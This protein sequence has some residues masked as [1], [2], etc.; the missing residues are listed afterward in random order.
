[1]T[2]D[3]RR[4]DHDWARLS[5]RGLLAGGAAMGLGLA[6][7]GAGWSTFATAATTSTTTPQPSLLGGIIAFVDSIKHLVPGATVA[8]VDLLAGESGTYA[9][10][11]A[12]L[13]AKPFA[14]DTIVSIDS[15]TKMFTTIMLAQAV[16]GKLGRDK[17]LTLDATI[18]PYLQPYMEQQGLTLAPIVAGI[19]LEQLSNY[20]SGFYEHPWNELDPPNYTIPELVTWLSEVQAVGEDKAG[21][22]LK[23]SP[24]TTYFYSDVALGLLGFILA[25]QLMLA[26]S[27]GNPVYADLVHQHLVGP[28]VLNLTDTSMMPSGA[29]LPRVATGYQYVTPPPNPTFQTATTVTDPPPFLGGGGGLRTTAEDMVTFLEALLAPPALAHL[30]TAVPLT[31]KVSFDGPTTTVGTIK[32]GL[33]WDPIFDHNGVTIHFKNGGG[34]DGFYTLLG[35]APATKRALFFNTNVAALDVDLGVGQAFTD[36]LAQATPPPS[37]TSTTGGSSTTSSG[38]P[39]TTSVSPSTTSR[40]GTPATQSTIRTAPR[41]TG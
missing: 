41:F 26:S 2:D 22:G 12:E 15:V 32:T 10:G 7:G 36:L 4:N 28:S 40:A 8:S 20:T 30:D 21:H 16:T 9:V 39:T 1:M 34:S 6:A 14:A 25:D 3:G 31:E 37:T 24:G 19:T 35:V 5:R 18:G 38:G 11:A 13:N 33:G 29:Q 23:V 27:P 17:P